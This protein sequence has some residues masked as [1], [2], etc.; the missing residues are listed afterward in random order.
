M[1]AKCAE[2]LSK[3]TDIDFIDLNCGCPID[4]VFNQGCGSA[5]MA[6]RKRLGE[7]VQGELV[8]R[9]LELRQSE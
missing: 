7:I 5:L 9:R 8:A 1:M 4:L 2:L 3:E 6:R